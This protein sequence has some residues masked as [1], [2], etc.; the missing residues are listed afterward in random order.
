MS[1]FAHLHR[2][3]PKAKLKVLGD[4]GWRTS[5]QHKFE[6]HKIGVGVF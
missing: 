6:L 4:N 2:D 1:L 3:M 5:E